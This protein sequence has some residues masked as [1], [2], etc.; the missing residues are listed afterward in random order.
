MRTVALQSPVTGKE[1]AMAQSE[2][3]NNKRTSTT[4]HI[5]HGG[6]DSRGPHAGIR[7]ADISDWDTVNVDGNL[8]SAVDKHGNKTIYQ[9]EGDI[10]VHNQLNTGGRIAISGGTIR[11]H[12]TFSTA[13]RFGSPNSPVD[14][15]VITDTTI[16]VSDARFENGIIGTFV[17]GDGAFLRDVTIRGRVQGPGNG[18]SCTTIDSPNAVVECERLDLSDGSERDSS[19]QSSAD[20]SVGIIMSGESDGVLRLHQC[21]INQFPNNSLYCE[22]TKHGGDGYAVITQHTGHGSDRDQLRVGGVSVIDT[23][24]LGGH[25]LRDEY[26]NARGVWARHSTDVKIRNVTFRSHHSDAGEGIRVDSTS[27]NVSIENCDLEMRSSHR[28]A[29]G[30]CAYSPSEEVQ[31]DASIHIKDTRIW[32]DGSP[33][34]GILILEGREDSTIENTDVNLPNAEDE[35]DHR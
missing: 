23:A 21:E 28:A 22:P 32:G 18:L 16:D 34:D 3:E 29:R 33:R 4:N 8:P 5:T 15:I 20:D 14:G 27:G 7:N 10:D 24:D 12:G 9:I 31:G 26:D 6:S 19:T 30:V 2:G 13:L 17:E 11:L 35:I 25:G 1:W